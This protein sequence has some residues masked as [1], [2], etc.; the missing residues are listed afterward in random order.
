MG[1]N[2]W[3]A[4]RLV[5]AGLCFWALGGEA[6]LLTLGPSSVAPVAMRHRLWR[7]GGFV[8]V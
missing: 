3:R 4:W 5:G 6:G 1:L 7:P 2:Q 8:F